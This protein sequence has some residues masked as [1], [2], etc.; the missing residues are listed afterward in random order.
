MFKTEKRIYVK[1]GVPYT[2]V[3]NGITMVG[4]DEYKDEKFNEEIIYKNTDGKV[5]S[6]ET[7]K[8]VNQFKKK[9]SPADI[10][11]IKEKGEVLFESNKKEQI[12]VSLKEIIEG[13]PVYSLIYGTTAVS[14]VE[15]NIEFI[16]ET[17][18]SIE[19]NRESLFIRAEY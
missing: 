12:E 15:G 14:C 7:H 19:S 5:F 6:L 10:E 17:F 3:S 11:E 8:F 4:V 2:I 13:Y 16:E 1:T 18:N 9:F